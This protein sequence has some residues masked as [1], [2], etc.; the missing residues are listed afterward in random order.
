VS[1]V[2]ILDNGTTAMT[3]GQVHPGVGE[4]LSGEPGRALDFEA[5]ARAVGIEQVAVVDPYDAA[6]TEEALREAIESPEPAVVIAR[7]E[8]VLLSRW[9]QA[10]PEHDAEICVRCG[11]CIALGCPAISAADDGGERPLP[12]ISEAL[13]VGC[14]LCVQTCRVGAL[15]APEGADA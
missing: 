13:C 1:T 11:R 5:L 3:G 9:R 15:K 4:T 14:M 12:E 10:P 2:V 7:R 8:C 6:A